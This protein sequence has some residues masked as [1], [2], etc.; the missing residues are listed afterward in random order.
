MEMFLSFRYIQPFVPRD[1]HARL[2]E[3]NAVALIPACLC[4]CWRETV[5]T[6]Q[7]NIRNWL[8]RL[9]TNSLMGSLLDTSAVCLYV[10]HNRA[11]Q[12]AR[13]NS[14]HWGPSLLSYATARSAS[15]LLSLFYKNAMFC[16]CECTQINVESLQFRNMYYSYVYDQK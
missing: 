8:N 10:L 15:C 9:G 3:R 14:L 11:A 16:Y 7:F 4:V 6:V 13:R 2:S 5:Q 1:G 12:G